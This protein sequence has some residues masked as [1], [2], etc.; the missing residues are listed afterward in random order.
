MFNFTN[1]P[2][3]KKLM[4]MIMTAVFFAVLL[5]SSVFITY[6]YLAG[7]RS[8]EREF[9]ATSKI[10]ASQS[11]A[12]LLFMDIEGLQENLDSLQLNEDIITGCIYDGTNQLLAS[13]VKQGRGQACPT[14]LHPPINQFHQGSYSLSEPVVVDNE[15]AGHLYMQV[16]LARLYQQLTTYILTMLI[17][18]VAISIAVYLLSEIL[19]KFISSPLLLL[20]DT[21]NRVS[22]TQDYTLRADKISADEIGE[23]VDTFN[24]MLDTIKRQNDRIKEDA[25]LLEQKVKDRTA[26]LAVANNELAVSNKELGVA[27]KE[28]EAFSYSVSHDLRAP[29]RAVD[30][31]TNALREDYGDQLD[32]MAHSFMDRACTASQ[33]MSDLIGTLLTLSRVSRKELEPDT[34]NLSTLAQAISRELQES[35]PERKVSL[36]IQTDIIAS[37][38]A[39]LLEVV[40]NNLIG[41]AWKYT[42]YEA[43]PEITVGCDSI[44]GSTVYYVK[45]NGAGFDKKYA[46]DLFVAFKRLHA[47]DQF[48][49][50]GIGLATVARIVHRHHGDIW[51]TSVLGQGACFYFTLNQ[52][53]PE[54]QKA[55]AGSTSQQYH[56][57]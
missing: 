42:G 30:G 48:E 9:S 52:P 26:E 11:E 4:L 36:T 2:I 1:L 44:D 8:M 43:H 16:S 10:V 40:L 24:S 20:K 22:K 23:L 29:L 50:T 55:D 14:E 28:L 35:E 37:A 38:D 31:Y 3:R 34:V 51:A 6:E 53:R 54:A 32:E 33:K 45:D 49:G 19:Q 57:L 39:Q 27:N 41:N 46:D 56:A 13:L 7:K 18:A 47:T 12:A 21:A 15:T 5:L 25:E 17:V